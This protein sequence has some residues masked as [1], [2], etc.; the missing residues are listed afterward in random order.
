MQTNGIVSH[1]NKNKKSH[2]NPPVWC[3]RKIFILLPVLCLAAADYF[4]FESKKTNIFCNCELVFKSSISSQ[5]TFI[6]GFLYRKFV[7]GLYFLLIHA[8]PLKK[9]T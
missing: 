5:S 1:S 9:K 8:A 3:L 6:G 2:T 4:L 7:M